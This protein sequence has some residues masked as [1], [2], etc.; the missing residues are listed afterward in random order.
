MFEM[1]IKKL[2]Q[3]EGYYSNNPSDSGGE[4]ILGIT[5]RD[6]PNDYNKVIA[7]YREGDLEAAQKEAARF[8]KKSFWNKHYGSLNDSLADVLFSISVNMGAGTVH[9]QLQKV[10]NH[11]FS[12]RLEID[13]IFGNKTLFACFAENQRSVRSALIYELSKRYYRLTVED[14]EDN[15]FLLG[16]LNRLYS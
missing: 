6:Y 2:F 11:Y 14:P 16:W 15:R 7:H 5:K 3:N 1:S 4:T 13:G 12:Y 10:L 9:K 8:Y